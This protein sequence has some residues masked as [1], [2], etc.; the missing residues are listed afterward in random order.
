MR[1]IGRARLTVG[2]ADF[3]GVFGQDQTPPKVYF[4]HEPTHRVG[5]LLRRHGERISVRMDDGRSR[6]YHRRNL[7][8]IG[9][10]EWRERMACNIFN[11]D[12]KT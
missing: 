12:F 7:K 10:K 11:A 5:F 1:D 4:L 3:R 8:P 6:T 2:Y 9:Y